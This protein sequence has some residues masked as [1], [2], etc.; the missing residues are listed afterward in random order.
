[1]AVD[2]S[3]VPTVDTHKQETGWENVEVKTAVAQCGLD[4][5]DD[6]SIESFR[7]NRKKEEL[8]GCSPLFPYTR[9]ILQDTSAPPTVK[10]V[11]HQAIKDAVPPSVMFWK[12][13]CKAVPDT[14]FHS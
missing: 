7:S 8:S 9:L 11:L 2:V 3:E 1:M 12:S 14:L 10:S 13:A 6:D 5:E 4:G